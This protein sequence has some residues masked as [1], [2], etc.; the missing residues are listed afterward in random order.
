MKNHLLKRVL[1]MIL[2][3]AMLAGFY[4]P[5]AQAASTGF[6]WKESDQKV[7]FD[8]TDREAETHVEQPY[9]V[10]DIVRV[11]IVLEKAS[12]MQAGFRSRLVAQNDQAMAYNRQLL[13]EQ[14]ELAGKISSQALGG[15]PLDVVWNLTV[16]GNIISA[17]V[18]YGKIPAIKRVNGVQDVFVEMQYEPCVV[19][20][21]ENVAQPQMFS[22]LGMAGS[23]QVWSNGYTG[24]GSRIAVIDTGTDINHQSL[25]AD[26]FLYALEQNAKAAGIS[27]SEYVKGLDLLDE[28]E[29]ASVLGD[30]KISQRISGLTASDLYIDE[31]LAFGANYVDYDLNV[32]HIYDEQGEHGS[33]VAGIAT[34]NSWLYNAASDSY[35]KA[36]DYCFMQGVAP[37]AQLL[38]MKVFG[39]G[40]S[41]YDS[42][43]M[44]AIED[45]IVLGADVVNLSLA[46]SPPL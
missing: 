9:D 3:V 17:N 7:S 2:V 15:K 31:K 39:K 44:A 21:E 45:A 43:Y 4:V 1:S 28:Q 32:Q 6:S 38:T 19:E 30:L 5:G 12:T 23:Y 34:A 14:E 26:A 11:S 18:P 35:G 41:P 16:V 27:Y 24:A 42:D 36:M 25:D 29:I 20:R 37:E 33:H 10:T 40:G 22:S 8:L 13:T 46:C